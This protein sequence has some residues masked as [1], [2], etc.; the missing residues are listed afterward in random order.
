MCD[1]ALREYGVSVEVVTVG[2]SAAAMSPLTPFTRH[3]RRRVEEFMDATYALFKQV[4]GTGWAAQ[5]LVVMFFPR[6]RMY[7]RLHALH[8]SVTLAATL[9]PPPAPPRSV[10]PRVGA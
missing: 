4:G 7:A 5:W 8:H 10:W 6:A 2:R 9:P 1:A 3:Q